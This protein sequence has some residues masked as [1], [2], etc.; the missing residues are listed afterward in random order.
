MED[1]RSVGS[2]CLDIP[3][4]PSVSNEQDLFLTVRAARESAL[5]TTRPAA[6]GWVDLSMIRWVHMRTFCT[7]GEP[8]RYPGDTRLNILIKHPDTW[9]QYIFVRVLYAIQ[10]PRCLA[11]ISSCAIP[12]TF[13]HPSLPV[14]MP[15]V[16]DRTQEWGWFSRSPPWGCFFDE[17]LEPFNKRGA[18]INRTEANWL[19]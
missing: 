9:Y 14:V 2:V 19:A 13:S 1:K 7:I 18:G 8:R 4:R 10:F 5:R 15:L 12:G 6:N 16:L 3:V 17:T 11:C